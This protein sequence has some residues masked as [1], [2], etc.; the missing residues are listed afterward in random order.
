M[1]KQRG[2]RIAKQKNDV[3]KVKDIFSK[4]ATGRLKK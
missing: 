3:R 2:L 1:S 4:Y